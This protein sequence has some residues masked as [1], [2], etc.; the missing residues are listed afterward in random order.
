MGCY[1]IKSTYHNAI[2]SPSGFGEKFSALDFFGTAFSNEG[3]SAA[4]D[5]MLDDARGSPGSHN[6]NSESTFL[7]G[8]IA[9]SRQ[10]PSRLDQPQ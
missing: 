10:I 7:K 3:I 4:T 8:W 2:P 9:A 1:I 5:R 6:E